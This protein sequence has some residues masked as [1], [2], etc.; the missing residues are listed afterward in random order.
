KMAAPLAVKV[1]AALA[2][3]GPS[4]VLGVREVAAAC[5]VPFGALVAMGRHPSGCLHEP[6]NVEEVPGHEGRVA[7]GEVVLGPAGVRVEVRGSGPGF[8]D[9][10]GVGLGRDDVTEVLQR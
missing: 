4:A 8:T 2:P 3:A 1:Q 6:G 5:R 7:V 10:A 9:P